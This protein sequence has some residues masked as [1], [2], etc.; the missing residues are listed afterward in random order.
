MN[1]LTEN[2]T[3]DIEQL[4]LQCGETPAF[5]ADL[6]QH[7]FNKIKKFDPE[8]GAYTIEHLEKTSNEARIFLKEIG[9][10]EKAADITADAFGIHDAGKILQKLELWAF[11]TEKR[12]RTEA[13]KRERELHGVLGIKVLGDSMAAL[14][15]NPVAD[16]R[17]FIILAE[18][19]MVLHHE[20]KDASGPQKLAVTDRALMALTI[21]DQIDGKGKVK[22]LTA[23]FEDMN[24]KHEAQFDQTMVGQYRESSMKRNIVPTQM[25]KPAAEGLQI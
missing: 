3:F 11:A 5:F 10:D 6:K 4:A 9:I 14:K 22:T 13:E 24:G 2:F 25:A 19:L 20:R 18:K 15:I 23:S 8:F 7:I 16:E 17:L 1:A 12:E 21:I